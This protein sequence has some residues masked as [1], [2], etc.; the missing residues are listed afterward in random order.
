MTN[1]LP[2]LVFRVVDTNTGTGPRKYLEYSTLKEAMEQ[3][4]V[5]YG[6]F[7]I[8]LFE[9]DFIG[10]YIYHSSIGFILDFNDDYNSIN[11]VIT[12]YLFSQ[13]IEEL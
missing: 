2:K 8:L 10:T 4:K 12:D 9:D 3:G 5:N 11:A 6:S 7:D 1:K 13:G